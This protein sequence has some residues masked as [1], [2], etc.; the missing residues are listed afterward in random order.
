VFWF[1]KRQ[2]APKP[3]LTATVTDEQR[4]A[5]RAAFEFPIEYVLE[6][7]AGTRAALASDLSTGGLRIVGD[8]DLP[9]NALLTLRFTLPNELIA[10]EHVEKEV[11]QTTPRGKVK[12]KVMSPPDPFHEMCV[13]GRVVVAFLH[14]TRRRLMHGVAFVDIDERTQEEIQRF[15]HIWQL[16]QLRERAQR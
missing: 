8:E 4:K 13:R 3:P 2:P 16:R 10:G 14:L 12:R 15:I 1:R 9:E 5:Y 6:G 11:E 7:R